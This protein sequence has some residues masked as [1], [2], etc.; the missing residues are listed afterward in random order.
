LVTRLKRKLALLTD[1]TMKEKGRR[2][3]K[4]HLVALQDG[5]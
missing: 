5:K 2:V 3:Q 4:V 1:V